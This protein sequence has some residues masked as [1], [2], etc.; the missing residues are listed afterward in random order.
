MEMQA[1]HRH[2]IERTQTA[3]PQQM[4]SDENFMP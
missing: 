4:I 2:A 3:L 1:F